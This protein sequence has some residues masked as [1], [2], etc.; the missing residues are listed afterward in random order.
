MAIVNNDIGYTNDKGKVI[1]NRS[2]LLSVINLAAKEISGVS[3]LCD[4]VGGWFRKLFSH[5][6]YEGVRLGYDKDGIEIDIYMNVYFGVKVPDVAYKVQESIKNGVA[7]MLD[8]KIK[9]INIHVL[10]VDFA[11]EEQKAI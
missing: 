6:Y 9:C 11:K 4:N 3:S 8:V 7:S 5:K 1:C 2:I 10:G